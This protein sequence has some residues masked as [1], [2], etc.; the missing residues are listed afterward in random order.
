MKSSA[1]F[2]ILMTVFQLAFGLSV[3]AVTRHYYIQDT[4]PTADRQV[5]NQQAPAA[6]PETGG[7]SELEQLIS[8]FPGQPAI[9]DPLVLAQQADEYFVTQQ[10]DRAAELYRQLLATDPQNVD[11]YNNLGITLHYLSRSGEALN[12]LNQGTAVDPNYQRIWLTLGFVNSQV[13]NISEAR[14]ALNAAIQ[15]GADSE[16][17]RSASDML[18][19]I[20]PG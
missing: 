9:T 3:F 2:W 6:W 15:L 20:G 8:A 18:Q 13:G 5:T 11:T 10:Y 14:N 1:R 12:V 19:S 17:G 16:V 4:T 7:D